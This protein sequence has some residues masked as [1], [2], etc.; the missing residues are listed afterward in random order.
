MSDKAIDLGIRPTEDE[1]FE[2][3]KK[4]DGVKKT[5]R[6]EKVENGWVIT[7]EKEWEEKNPINDTS[8][9]KYNTWKY[10]S[11]NNPLKNTNPEEKQSQEEADLANLLNSVAAAQ[12]DIMI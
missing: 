3:S 7:I 6:G 5:V 12:G 2:F 9:W 11:T 8:E 1:N 10:I 4:I